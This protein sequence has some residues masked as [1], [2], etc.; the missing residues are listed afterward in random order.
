MELLHNENRSHASFPMSSG[1]ED[2][3]SIVVAEPI[4]MHMEVEQIPADNGR[5]SAI[6]F[7]HLPEDIQIKILRYAGLLRPCLIN[8]AFER[9]RFKHDGALCSNGNSVRM[10][11]VSWTG[12]W[13]DPYHGP[14]NHPPLPV[15]ILRTSHAARRD[16][17]ALFFAHN[18][19][20]IYLFGMSEYRFFAASTAW[21]LQHMR[22]LHLELGPRESRFLKIANGIHGTI[23][24]VWTNFCR[25]ATGR[26]PALKYF[27]MKC[28]VKDLL[29]ASKLMCAMDPF[30][31]LYH[32]AFHFNSSQDDYIR[33]VIKRAAW[34]LTDNL[35]HPPFPYTRLPKE[36][37]LMI[38]E[39]VLIKCFDPYLPASERDTGVVGLLDRKMGRPIASPLACCG[40]CSPLRAMC[41]CTARQTA[42]STSCSCFSSPLPY[43]LVS[44]GFYED[45][46]RLFFCRTN[47]TFVEEDPEATIR[48]LVHIPTPSLMQI[49]HLTF[50]FPPTHRVHHK[51][52]RSQTVA[53]LSWSVLRRFIREHFDLPHVSLSI[54]DMAS[55]N[56]SI[57]RNRYMRKMLKAFTDLQDLR[58]LR[59]YLANDPSF[60][61]ELERAVMGTVSVKRYAPYNLPTFGQQLS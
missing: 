31:S 61:K 3:Q 55:R 18:H 47:F 12:T 8:I 29:V 39:H 46:R 53:L 33:P 58:E 44:R 4:D 5:E 57:A 35:S 22:S 60:E 21:G 23:L 38:L 24:K 2:F 19:F 1:A 43:F 26:M 42:F 49:R 34:R 54:I 30:P 16:L 50:K 32:C 45:C 17:G 40:T 20:S 52:A 48:F 25:N 6:T 56:S 37:Q 51:S 11:R 14:C 41:F 28:K 27:S 15:E 9:S 7:F 13:V 59:V 10:S 36:V